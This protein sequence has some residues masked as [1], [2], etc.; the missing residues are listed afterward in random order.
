MVNLVS[1]L[2]ILIAFLSSISIGAPISASDGFDEYEYE[3]ATEAAVQ[4]L[5]SFHQVTHKIPLHIKV[6]V[7][8]SPESF[9]FHLPSYLGDVSTNLRRTN[10]AMHYV[11][12]DQLFA[13]PSVG[14]EDP[15]FA[16]ASFSEIHFK[17]EIGE[18]GP[19]HLCDEDQLIAQVC[20]AFTS[21]VG[22][23]TLSVD[24]DF[25]RFESPPPPDFPFSIAALAVISVLALAI[26]GLIVYLAA[27]FIKLLLNRPPRVITVIP[28]KM[29]EERRLIESISS[30]SKQVSQ[31]P[32]LSGSLDSFCPLR[33]STPV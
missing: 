24:Y 2:L 5:S 3:E 11:N 28:E 27:I 29:M 33:T 6:R 19:K 12:F 18:C 20:W 16:D 9:F 1:C 8:S 13:S 10:T 7:N 21:P 32:S 23:G 31:V 25:I 26:F 14:H 17:V 15:I 4:R 30:I 22:Y